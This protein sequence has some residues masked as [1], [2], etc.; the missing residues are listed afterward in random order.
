M[1]KAISLAGNA[2]RQYGNSRSVKIALSLGPYGA[3]MTTAQEFTGF[4][5]PPYGP[6][7]F[8]PSEKNTNAFDDDDERDAKEREAQ[9]ALE[10]FHFQRLKVF[11]D[12]PDS[13]EG[14]DLIAFETV[15]LVRE[16][17]AIRGA[18]RRLL[19]ITPIISKSWWIST[20][21]PDGRY[22]EEST[23]GGE[24]LGVEEVVSALLSDAQGTPAPDGIGVNCTDLKHLGVIIKGIRD[25]VMLIR[26]N[27]KP[28]LVL[29]PNGGI[30]YDTVN[31]SWVGES[32]VASEQRA[33]WAKRLA[34][35]G[36]EE[37]ESGVWTFVAI[38]GCCKT[39]PEHIEELRKLR[40]Q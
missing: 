15:P 40:E 9:R 26:P 35:I 11:A 12:D 37:Q 6:K 30:T 7:A 22:P 39:G 1:R 27:L 2:R 5:P 31:R 19:Y 28:F 32:P 24:R 14:I 29:Y 16:I 18:M 13:W 20:V 3:S 23:P 21:W 34:S 38:G 8:S 10:E 4:Y 25:N 33:I 36:K 17:R